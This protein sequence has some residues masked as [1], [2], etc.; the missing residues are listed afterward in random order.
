[1]QNIW[2][3]TDNKFVTE[4]Q[5]ILEQVKFSIRRIESDLKV[6]KNN[7]EITNI[8]IQALKEN[9]IF[10]KDKKTKI[11]SIAEYKTISESLIKF[12]YEN[13]LIKKRNEELEKK[14]EIEKAKILLIETEI[15]KVKFKLLEFKKNEKN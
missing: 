6:N 8:K 1:M 11:I 3:P 14:L 7:V 4:L 9:L 10:L 2:T 13:F 15:E 12:N 5:V